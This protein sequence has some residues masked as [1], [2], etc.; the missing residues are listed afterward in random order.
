MR[1]GDDVSTQGAHCFKDYDKDGE[2]YVEWSIV[3]TLKLPVAPG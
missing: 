3:C 2:H 1:H